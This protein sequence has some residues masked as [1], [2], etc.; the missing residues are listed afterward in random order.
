[1][2]SRKPGCE[3]LRDAMEREGLTGEDL[4]SRLTPR[5]RDV[6]VMRWRSGKRRP[7]RPGHKAQLR[8]LFKIPIDAWDGETKKTR[9]E[10]IAWL[11]KHPPAKPDPRQARLPAVTA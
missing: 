3:L 10:R 11:E 6:T 9:P 8:E 1:M 4:A 7:Q 2:P 5:V